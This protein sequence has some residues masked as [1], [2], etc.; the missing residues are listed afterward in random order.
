MITHEYTIIKGFAADSPPEALTSVQTLGEDHS[1]VIE[2]DQ[3]VS[4]Q[5]GQA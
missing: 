4:I 1:V 3:P 5:D 2:D